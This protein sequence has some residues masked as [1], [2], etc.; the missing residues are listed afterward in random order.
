MTEPVDSRTEPV[1]CTLDE[2]AALIREGDSV[3]GGGLPLWRKPLAL[4]RAVARSGVRG[5][6]Y[7]AFLASLDAELLVSAGCVAQLEY[8]YVGRDVLGSSRV[9]ARRSDI[10]RRCR[11]EFEY[12]AALR[13]RASGVDALPDAFGEPVPAAM[14]DVCVLHAS[15][16]DAAGNVYAD[17]LDL[18]EEDD[19][20][21]AGAARR[22]LVTV[23]RREEPA[24]P[25]ATLLL[26]A[27]SVTAYAVAPQGA[28]PLGMSG[29]YS[30][31]L[32]DLLGTAVSQ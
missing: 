20:L 5:L 3:V 2:L 29:A 14:Y 28:S 13:A 9:L 10:V 4:L 8:G 21:L 27:S 32:A 6:T 23:E 11:T 30:P 31:D 24:P 12:W 18:M 1:R 7:S 17:P 16:V 25:G 22:V 15:L 19:R 26:P